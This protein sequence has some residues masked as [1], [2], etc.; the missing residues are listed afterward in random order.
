LPER[1]LDCGAASAGG[2]PIAWLSGNG[3]DVVPGD[4][5]ASWG[6]GL[7]TTCGLRNVGAPSEGFGLHGDVSFQPAQVMTPFRGTVVDGDLVLER[8]WH[9]DEDAVRLRDVCR[10][11]GVTSEPAPFLYHVNFGPPFWGPGSRLLGTERPVPRDEDAAAFVDAWDR[12]PEEGGPE[13]VYEHVPAPSSVTVVG[14]GLRVDVRW[15]GLE[16]LH[17]WID[18]GLGALAIEPANCSV[19]GR[20]FDRAEGRLPILEPGQERVTWLEIRASAP[21]GAAARL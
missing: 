4:W 9:L 2:V 1:A 20:A 6:G 18:P 3:F 14:A 8:E 21:V 11:E 7:V 12:F 17:Q 15:G 16:R 5:R 19:L 10:N 13:R